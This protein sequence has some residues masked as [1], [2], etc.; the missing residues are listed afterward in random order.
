MDGQAVGFETE[1]YAI[2]DT[3]QYIRPDVH[4]VCIG[5]AYGNAAMLLASGKPGNRYVLP[6][7]SI[8]LCP[9]KLNRKAHTPPPRPSTAPYLAAA[10]T[11]RQGPPPQGQQLI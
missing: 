5:K 8:M 10:A 1:A 3:L 6:N 11:L 7:A 4:T 2:L 9:P